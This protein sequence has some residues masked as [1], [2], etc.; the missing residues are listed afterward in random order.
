MKYTR[1][2]VLY[3]ASEEAF[4]VDI[5]ESTNVNKGFRKTDLQTLVPK[6]VTQGLLYVVARDGA[7]IYYKTTPEGYKHLLQLQIAYR[8]KHNKDYSEQV[9]ELDFLKEKTNE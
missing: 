9:I 6:L 1:E 7:Q 5:N 8:K 3:L 2:K 4:G